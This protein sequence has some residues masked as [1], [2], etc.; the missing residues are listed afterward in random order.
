MYKFSNSSFSGIFLLIHLQCWK[1]ARS[2]VSFT[3]HIKSKPREFLWREKQQ[4]RHL[5]DAENPP[6]QTLDFCF[7][8]PLFQS[9][10]APLWCHH[11]G[12][13][14]VMSLA[15]SRTSKDPFLLPFSPEAERAQ[16]KLCSLSLSFLP[17]ELFKEIFF[18]R[19]CFCL[20]L[21]GC[22]GTLSLSVVFPSLCFLFT[23]E[24]SSCSYT[25]TL[26]SWNCS[27]FYFL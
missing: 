18:Q 23:P 19:N 12:T 20:I 6:N 16:G 3:E 22:L 8:I 25:L 15:D 26:T 9:F 24:R 2:L 4:G 27:F 5:F 7:P 1:F 14:C 10:P 13:C 17:T 21:Y 11:S